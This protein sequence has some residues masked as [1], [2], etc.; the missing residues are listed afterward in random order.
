MVFTKALHARIGGFAPY[1]YV[2]DWDF[3]LRAM[4]LGRCVYI[5]RYLTAYRMHPTNTINE[6]T[7][8]VAV[9]SK[10]LFDRLLRD[11]PHLAERPNFRIGIQHNPDL[12]SYHTANGR[13]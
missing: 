2:H 10:L 13:G 4:A 1:R 9:E 12:V 6:N 3:A 11:F 5:R 8:K 7:G